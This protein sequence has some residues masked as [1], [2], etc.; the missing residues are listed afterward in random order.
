MSEWQPI[1]TAPEGELVVV[2]WLDPEDE[3]NPERHDFDFREDGVWVKHADN[4]EHFIC[5]A[6]PGSRGPR[7]EAPYTHWSK[8][9]PI[10]R[11]P[12]IEPD[13]D[14]KTVDMF[15]EQPK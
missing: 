13:R 3:T 6:P 5:V 2:G 10:P 14:T 1:S 8:I 7:E 12:A 4:Y 11:P 9:Q 15:E